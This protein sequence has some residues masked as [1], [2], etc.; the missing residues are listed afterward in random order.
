MPAKWNCQECGESYYS[1]WNHETEQTILCDCGVQIHNPYY[2]VK[3]KKNV[4]AE[5]SLEYSVNRI[6]R[7]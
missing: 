1:S 5:V 3:E 2:G 6:I 4:E 7:I